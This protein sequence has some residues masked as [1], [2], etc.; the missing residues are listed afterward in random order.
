MADQEKTPRSK[1]IALANKFFGRREG[2]SLMEFGQEL[3]ELTDQDCEDLLKGLD[4][5]NP[6]LTY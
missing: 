2:Q 3:K 1:V 5:P 4:G 6:T